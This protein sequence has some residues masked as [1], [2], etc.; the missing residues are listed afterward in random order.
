M[1]LVY[2]LEQNK[3]AEFSMVSV[4]FQKKQ[5]LNDKETMIGYRYK[6]IYQKYLYNEIKYFLLMIWEI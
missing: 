2:I 6:S 5:N 3:L 1:H 4:F